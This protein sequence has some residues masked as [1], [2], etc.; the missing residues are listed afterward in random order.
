[1]NR[2]RNIKLALGHGFSVPW[3][4]F[5]FSLY[6]VLALLAFNAGQVEPAAGL[7]AMLVSVLLALL[8]FLIFWL[9]LR[10]AHRAAFLALLWCVLF[11][12]YGHVYDLLNK[13]YP[14]LPL[15]P[16]L[17]AAWTFFAILSVFWV[18][19]PGLTF[20][21]FASGL[22]TVALGLVIWSAFQ[23][24]PVTVSAKAAHRAVAENAP[25]QELRPRA[26]QPLPDVYYFIL[27][28]YAR[29]D[30]LE[31]AYHYDNSSFV[32]ALQDRGFY[33]AGCSQSNYVRTEI[34]LA[35]S[36]NMLYLQDLDGA[37]SGDSIARAHLW[38][39]LKHSAVRYNFESL[40]YK[41]VNFANGFAWMELRDAGEFHSTPP[42]SAA[43]TEFETLFLES[44]LA[45]H[46]KDLGWLDA[47]AVS[48]QNFRDRFNLVFDSL[49]DIARDPAPTFAYLHLISPHPPF[50]FGPTGEPTNPADFWNEQ[51]QYPANLYVKGYKNQLAWLNAKMLK[52]IDTILK[53]SP[54]PPVI[55]IQGDHGP[56]LQPREKHFTI[57]NAYYLPGHSDKLYPAISPVNSFRLVF[58]EYFGGDYPL[59]ADVSYFSPVPKLYQFSEIPNPCEQ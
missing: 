54:T 30:L 9:V 49:D 27:D 35:S 3:Y 19:R 44:T 15:T 2:F 12:S 29:A 50:V 10:K 20:S 6:P 59:L 40:G 8:F 38:D 52:G 23:A 7:R 36:L 51:R 58:D 37:F 4:P 53:D 28:S 17:L 42:F 26:G 1:M 22:N 13:K 14:D 56:W 5:V 11:F 21:S 34:S 48:A 55:I 25:I 32:S 45:R 16:W 39:S 33:V 43:L 57:L 47:D 24:F 18:T 46:V 41:T 31:K